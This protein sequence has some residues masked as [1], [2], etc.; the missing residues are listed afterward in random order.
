MSTQNLLRKQVVSEVRKRKLVV[1]TITILTFIYLSISLFF[2]DMGLIRYW[3]LRKTRHNLEKEIADIH[4]Q[5]SHLKAQ[6]QL[7]K[8]DP[9]YKEKMAR[10]EFGLAKPDEFIFQFEK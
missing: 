4:S 9:F 8:E 2:G 1:I 3:E 6:L 7:L 5:N 10:E